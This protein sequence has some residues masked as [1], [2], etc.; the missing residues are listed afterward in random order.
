MSEEAN[1]HVTAGLAAFHAQD[2]LSAIAEL[3]EATRLDENNFRAF[4][5]LG[6][7]YGEIGKYEAAIGAFKRASAIRPNVPSVH[8]NL[9]QAYEAAGVP[10]EAAYEYNK[11]L[12]LNPNYKLALEAYE[13]LKRR[14]GQKS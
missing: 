10:S 1:I 13:D 4:L 12:E 9:G 6:A 5:Y 7:C 2:Y 14:L 11:A 8:Y 3:E